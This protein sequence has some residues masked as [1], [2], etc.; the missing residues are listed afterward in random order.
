[1][2]KSPDLDTASLRAGADFFDQSGAS[3]LGFSDARGHQHADH[4]RQACRE[5]QRRATE[6]AGL[7]RQRAHRR[8]RPGFV[9]AGGR[10]R[11]RVVATDRR[12]LGQVLGVAV[13]DRRRQRLRDRVR[14]GHGQADL[15]RSQER[16]LR[17]RTVPPGPIRTTTRRSTGT[18]A[19]A[20][21][22][23]RRATRR[24]HSTTDSTA[25]SSTALLFPLL[26]LKSVG[27][28]NVT[29]DLSLYKT[30]Q[31]FRL[32][33][34]PDDHLEWLVGMFYTRE[35][36]EQAQAA[37]AQTLSLAP[38]PG[39][40]PLAVISLPST[41][42]E[43]AGFGDLTWKFNST[44]DIAAGMR[45]AH[46]DQ[47]FSQITSGALTGDTQRARQFVR[48]RI[49]LFVEPALP[50]EPGLDDLRAHR[51][52]LSAW[53]PEPLAARR[54]GA[55]RCVDADELRGGHQEPAARPQPC[56]RRRDL[57]RRVGQDPGWG[58]EQRS[59]L[60]RQRRLR[61]Q[62][63]PG[64]LDPIHAD[65]GPASRPQRRLHRRRADR[66]RAEYRRPQWRS[67]AEH[68][69]VQRRRPRRT[70]RS[71]SAVAG[72]RV[73]APACAMS[74]RRRANSRTVPPRCRR[75][76]T[77][78]SIST[79]TSRTIAGRCAS[80]PRID[81]RTRLHEPVVHSRA[82]STAASRASGSATRAAY[83]RRR[84]R[85]KF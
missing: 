3:D 7:H 66:R 13:E 32:A 79:P 15:R 1:M 33:S 85:P 82:R 55:G 80:S 34:K 38:I 8:E 26:G 77:R 56:H 63:R 24:P 47:T 35:T 39:L 36:S 37:S 21:S 53:W 9:L 4:R 84:F 78:C 10:A 48:R 17:P 58:R 73:S 59:F 54:A 64:I 29:Y 6:F 16:Q 62:P 30:T 23:R 44:F 22:S 52:R 42:K 2:T 74:V 83:D 18:S 68:P 28:S 51:E 19:G 25:A 81:R 49:H 72:P 14:S 75:T 5:R 76:R 11:D 20:T 41:Y 40:D 71:R 67:P 12:P 46:N 43:Y 61:T 45:W 70:I 69:E 50:P 57:R 27:V 65:P 31:E 60:S